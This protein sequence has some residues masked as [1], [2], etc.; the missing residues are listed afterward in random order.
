MNIE[1]LKSIK[2]IITHDNCP[3]GRASALICR[4][5]LPHAEIEFIQYQTPR[6]KTI[7]PEPGVLFVDF[8]P[9]AE[10][11]PVT[12]ENKN[13]PL[14][15][16]GKTRIQ[17]WVDAGTLVLDHHK[18]AE[19]IVAMFGERGVFANETNEP[20][21]SGAMLAFREVWAPRDG[22]RPWHRPRPKSEKD[23]ARAAAAESSVHHFATLAG[24]RD[25]W[26]TKHPLWGASGE[27]AAAL[28]FWPWE[29]LLAAGVLGLEPLLKIGPVLRA[30]DFERD[31]KTIAEAYTIEFADR[32]FL[33]FE[34]LHTSDIADRVDVDMVIGW[35]Y[36]READGLKMQL[37]CR[38]RG[39]FSA[40]DFAKAH[41]GGGH[42]H[43]A[44]FKIP[45]L[46][47]NTAAMLVAYGCIELLLGKYLKPEAFPKLKGIVAS[48]AAIAAEA[49][50]TATLT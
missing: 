15:E 37:S 4:E 8:T 38:S 24:V 21:V 5:A 17:T 39:D 26:Q 1:Y 46:P 28:M 6:H 50:V 49:A 31:T 27:Q 9:W 13:P 2:K 23:K 25:T 11:E 41:G 10:R 18:G 16:A 42:F 45:L 44:G 40:L 36:L 14:S 34:G 33:C 43:A 12:P 19:D 3:D 35:H 32:K 47:E 20:G 30:R 48:G 7:E 22:A 29:T